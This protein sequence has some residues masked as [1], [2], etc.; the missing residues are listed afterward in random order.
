MN[1]G[2]HLA[3]R[4]SRGGLV[5][6]CL[7]VAI[8][9]TYLVWM[10]WGMDHMN[11]KTV[12]M[13]AMTNWQPLDLLLVWVMWALMMVGMM[14]PSAT[15]MLL[16]FAALARRVRPPRPASHT[17]AFAA[18]YLLVWTGFSA[19]ATMLQWSLLKWRLISPMMEATSP[20]MAGWFLVFAGAYQFTYWKV[21]C[22]ESCRVPTEFLVKH[23][24]PGTG[25]ALIM[26]LRHGGYCLGC[27]W[28]LMALLFVLGVMNLL[29]I[30]GLTLLVLAE[31]TLPRAQWLLRIG[32]AGLSGWGLWLLGRAAVGI[33]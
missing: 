12:L 4:S 26:G 8:A 20:W 17:L 33:A 24:R 1:P 28:A 32:G 30:V 13:P 7:A 25:G 3:A 21:A 31:K 23:W 27:C 6:L 5:L 29:W 2:D 15:P 18:G 11:A 16:G 19:A 22:L 14:L 10:A 9:W